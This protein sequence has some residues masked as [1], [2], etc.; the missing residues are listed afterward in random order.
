MPKPKHIGNERR[1]ASVYLGSIIKIFGTKMNLHDEILIKENFFDD[2]L[3]V[4][5]IALSSAYTPCD[6][7]IKT[8]IY[9]GFRA[10]IRKREIISNFKQKLQS[11]L[12]KEISYLTCKFHLNPSVSMQGFPHNDSDL[13]NSFAGV[14]YLNEFVPIQNS[15]TTIYEDLP[16][17]KVVEDY[18]EDYR[19]KM[20]IVYSTSLNPQNSFKLKFSDECLQFKENILTP[21]V[22]VDNI[23]N[24]LVCYPSR[25]LHS[26]G[27]YFG[28]EKGNSRLTFVFH[29]EFHAN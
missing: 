12:K 19:F 28:D 17:Q 7:S 20:E 21:I 16:E 25:V 15:G 18:I 23:F 3:Y 1:T 6:F 2:P 27:L 13:K 11:C 14:V 29:G 24:R 5:N 4:R 26:P 8:S 22:K 9:S 10:E